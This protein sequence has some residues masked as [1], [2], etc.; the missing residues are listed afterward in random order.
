LSKKIR[1]TTIVKAEIAELAELLQSESFNLK[2]G[3]VTHAKSSKFTS[4]HTDNLI[5]TEL[6]R[7]FER[8]LPEIAQRFLGSQIMVTERFQ[9]SQDL[10]TARIEI[11]IKNAPLE[12]SGYL[13]L[14]PKNS[15]TELVLDLEISASLPFFGEKIENFAEKTWSDISE[16]EFKLIE[17]AFTQQ[18]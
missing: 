8:E 1:N 3:D 17:T 2:K 9:W 12:I 16:I 14:L 5:T 6:A 18:A 10:T 11:E 15:S 7:E 13:M 4:S